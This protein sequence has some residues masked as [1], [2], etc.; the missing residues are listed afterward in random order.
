MHVQHATFTRKRNLP[1]VASILRSTKEKMTFDAVD[2]PRGV[3]HAIVSAI[4]QQNFAFITYLLIYED[5]NDSYGGHSFLC[6]VAKHGSVGVF[7]LLCLKGAD[8][9]TCG[10]GSPLLHIAIEHGRDA[11]VDRLLALPEID[12][13]ERGLRNRTALHVAA[14]H[15]WAA[16][17]ARVLLC[18]VDTRDCDGWTPLFRAMHSDS[19]DAAAVLLNHDADVDARNANRATPVMF[20]KDASCARLLGAAGACVDVVDA[21]GESPL[22]FHCRI[23]SRTAVV[24][25]LLAC[26][27]D[28]NIGNLRGLVPLQ[29]CSGREMACLLFAGGARPPARSALFDPVTMLDEIH[30]ARL[31]VARERVLVHSTRLDMMRWRAFEICLALQDLTLPALLTCNILESACRPWSLNVAFHCLWNVAV[32]VKHFKDKPKH[33]KSRP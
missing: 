7:D 22:L 24:R 32:C 18:G 2:F 6:H 16:C 14:H 25:I 15:D 17:A 28:A 13:R 29:V 23:A 3:K 8:I 30:L 33:A 31:S 20:A 27:A 21:A 4:E 10:C 1:S 19:V 11:M 5:P 9:V 26:G 12:V